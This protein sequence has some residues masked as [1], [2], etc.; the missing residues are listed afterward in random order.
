MC[1]E[2]IGPTQIARTLEN[3]KIYTPTMYEFKRTG[4]RLTGLNE[5]LPYA[6]SGRTVADILENII[7]LGHTLNLKT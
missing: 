7:Y 6:W 5:E 1:A 4:T 3:D 2:G